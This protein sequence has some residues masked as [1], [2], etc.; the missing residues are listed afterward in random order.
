MLAH[1]SQFTSVLKNLRREGWL[2]WH[3]LAAI[4]NTVLNYRFPED[5]IIQPSVDAQKEIMRRVS[6]PEDAAAVPV[7]IGLFTVEGMNQ[8]RQLSMMGLVQHWQLECHQE[9]PDFPASEGLLAAR[10]GYWEDDFPHDD[11]FAVGSEGG[12][13]GGLV[14][15]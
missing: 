1:S 4:A 2:D 8:H 10:Y 3:V 12:F 7:P 13:N 6:E 14:V 11:P 5:S 15:I 9:T